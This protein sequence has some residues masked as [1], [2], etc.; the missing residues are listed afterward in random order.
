[1]LP[2]RTFTCFSGSFSVAEIPSA[3]ILG[4]DDPAAVDHLAGFGAHGG[5]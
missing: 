4:P 1:M 2:L 3:Q 5:D